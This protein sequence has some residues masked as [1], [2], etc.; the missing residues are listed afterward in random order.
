[1]KF[2]EAVSVGI[3]LRLHVLVGFLKE[4]ILLFDRKVVLQLLLHDL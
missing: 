2:R 1:V 3:Q 4:R